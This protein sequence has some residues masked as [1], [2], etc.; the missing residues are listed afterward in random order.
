[1]NPNLKSQIEI[2]QSLASIAKR[3]QF[4]TS[5]KKTYALL[6]WRLGGG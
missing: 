4:L 2:Y 1:M 6:K 5:V 3:Y